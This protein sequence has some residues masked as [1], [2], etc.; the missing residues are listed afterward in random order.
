MD[1]TKKPL[2]TKKDFDK[3]TRPSKPSVLKNKPFENVQLRKISEDGKWA[4]SLETKRDLIADLDVK[5]WQNPKTAKDIFYLLNWITLEKNRKNNQYLFDFKK[6]LMDNIVAEKNKIVNWKKLV[7]NE[8]EVMVYKRDK[9][10]IREDL[11]RVYKKF[12][13]HG[14]KTSNGFNKRADIDAAASLL[15][16]ELAWFTKDWYKDISYVENWK[17][18]PGVNIDTSDEEIWWIRVLDYEK[19]KT[20]AKDWKIR[21]E[22]SLFGTKAI[23]NEHGNWPA[24][25]TRM[26]YQILKDF[27]KIPQ[28]KQRQVER[29]VQFVDIVDDMWYQATG[30][31]SPY[32]ERT[33]FGLYKF[34][35]TSFVFDYF[36]DANKTWFEYLDDKYLNDN[37]VFVF[38]LVSKKKEEKTLKEISKEKKERMEKAN[39]EILKTEYDW[40]FLMFGDNRFIVDLW[41][42]LTDG[43]ETVSI[44]GK[45]I[46][47]I[48]PW[49]WDLYIYSPFKLPNVIWWFEVSNE[50]FIIDK[51]WSWK[52]LNKL[53]N[54]FQYLSE[55]KFSSWS[56]DPWSK[57]NLKQ[58]IIEYRQKIEEKKKIEWEKSQ[59][60]KTR[61]SSLKNTFSNLPDLLDVEIW[62]DYDCIV[63]N[64]SW[65]IV[66]LTFD[67]K[68]KVRWRLHKNF[69][70]EF[71][72]KSLKQ[73]DR[74]S[75]NIIKNEKT[76]DKE[77]N[78][79]LAIET[80]LNKKLEE[81]I[82]IQVA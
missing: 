67:N 5:W 71:D 44:W 66:Y 82:E 60:E 56:K 75:V 52:N 31:V 8:K 6:R 26:V 72:F 32:L 68:D 49:S 27:D 21:R 35:P 17:W 62:K 12:T 14:Q 73:W 36:K 55:R 53:L 11:K 77:W 50:H 3:G 79:S 69:V 7:L 48:F 61:Y 43:P 16:L 4:Q 24:S 63:N 70:G 42:K 9:Q 46:I 37:K 30:I 57:R 33:I 45:W 34:L 81:K 2:V 58:E 1:K 23:L 39:K 19:A 78:D 22:K 41:W 74:L 18:G 59:Q 15:L 47:R 65:N 40:Y 64:V 54:E 10:A 51:I 13:V 76:K 28:D 20:S 38:N 80:K 29:F 25:S